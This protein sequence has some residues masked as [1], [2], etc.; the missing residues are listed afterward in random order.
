[1]TLNELVNDAIAA[2]R[3]WREEH[4]DD[5]EAHDAIHEIADG[6]VPVYSGDLLRLAAEHLHL[7][8][9]EP[10]LGPAFDGSPTPVNVIAANVFEHIEVALW[11][12]WQTMGDEEVT[13]DA[14]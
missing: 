8:T 1:M 4:P 14:A 3:E 13:D 12:A 5:E 10:E 11:E 6:Q 2:L 7:A 9:D